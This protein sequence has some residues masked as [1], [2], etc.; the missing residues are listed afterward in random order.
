MNATNSP[1][2]SWT[3]AFRPIPREPSRSKTRRTPGWRA[4]NAS[5]ISRVPSRLSEST[6]TTSNGPSWTSR[7]SRS[8]SMFGASLRTVRTTETNG[9]CDGLLPNVHHDDVLHRAHALEGEHE[10]ARRIALER[11]LFDVLARRHEDVGNP[12]RQRV[13]DE[14]VDHAQD[15]AVVRHHGLSSE[16]GEELTHREGLE[17]RWRA[18]VFNRW[19]VMEAQERSTGPPATGGRRSGISRSGNAYMSHPGRGRPAHGPSH[20]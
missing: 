11:A 1:W 5:A 17:R 6:R 20:S 3:P 9:R 8:C 13:D 4:A 16:F 14:V 15:L 12:A 10:P 19:P 2:A 18:G 7:L